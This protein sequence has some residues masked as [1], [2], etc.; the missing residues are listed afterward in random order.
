[1][2]SIRFAS[3]RSSRLLIV[4]GAVLLAA[5]LTLGAAEVGGMR[6]A[7]GAGGGGGLCQP[8]GPVCTTKAHNAFADFEGVA[9]DG[10]TFVD[11]SVQAFEALTEPG[12]TTGTFVFVIMSEYNN[13]TNTFIAAASNVDPNDPN[14]VPAFNGTAQFSTPLGSASVVGT[15]T[16]FDDTG[17]AAPWT[18]TINITWHGYGPT[19]TYID[20]F[21]AR[22]PGQFLILSHTHSTSQNAETTGVISDQAGNNLASVPTLD[23]L[24]QNATDGSVT[25]VKS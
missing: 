7:L 13:C 6:T 20:T 19:T 4:L 9:A 16:M 10:C 18:S 12:H 3:A 17:V 2:P 25:I 1:M 14:A 8:T 24:I 5:A 22:T 21:H 15:A 11:A 23:A